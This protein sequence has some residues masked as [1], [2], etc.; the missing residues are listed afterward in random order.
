MLFVALVLVSVA[1]T[2]AFG[3]ERTPPN[4]SACSLTQ[5]TNTTSDFSFEPSINA[6]GTRIAFTSR[7]DLTGDNPDGNEE[8]FL[9]DT[10]T[11]SLIQVTNT[12]GTL[13][14]SGQASINAAGTHIAFSSDGDVTGDNPDGNSELFLATCVGTVHDLVTMTSEEIG[15]QKR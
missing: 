7:A 1:G 13:F 10:T 9:A 2:R 5:L 14:G 11:G 6:A 8:I 3:A 15:E 4:D 12:I